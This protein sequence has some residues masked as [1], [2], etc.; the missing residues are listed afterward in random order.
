MIIV[1]VYSGRSESV[2]RVRVRVFEDYAKAEAYQNS[3]RTYESQSQTKHWEYAEIVGDG[4]IVELRSP[5]NY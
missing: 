5:V 1:Q 3:F 4:E 2:D